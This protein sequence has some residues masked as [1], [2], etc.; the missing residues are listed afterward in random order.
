MGNI[1]NNLGSIIDYV[2]TNELYNR[3][4]K[5]GNRGLNESLYNMIGSSDILLAEHNFYKN[6][7]KLSSIGGI[8]DIILK[9]FIEN[10]LSY[11]D[12]YSYDDYTSAINMVSEKFDIKEKIVSNKLHESVG[13]MIRVRLNNWDCRDLSMYYESYEY[14]YN[15]IKN[16]ISKKDVISNNFL[17]ES[18]KLFNDDEVINKVNE[19]F[20]KRFINEY[21]GIYNDNLLE[22]ILSFDIDKEKVLYESYKTNVLNELKDSISNNNDDVE[23][24]ALINETI[25]KIETN[26]SYN[27]ETIINNLIE[28]NELIG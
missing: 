6:I 22:S 2:N 12:I 9:E 15:Y 25:S 27:P 7:N 4:S 23:Y 5:K 8:N 10:N 17:N 26:M 13:N 20:R 16:G 24:V 28:L 14:I 19:I 11:F 21:S 18:T 1:N 3:V